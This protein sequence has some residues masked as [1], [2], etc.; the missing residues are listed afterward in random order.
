MIRQRSPESAGVRASSC[1]SQDSWLDVRKIETHGSV[2]HDTIRRKTTTFENFDATDALVS[3][4]PPSGPAKDNVSASSTTFS[5]EFG[6]QRPQREHTDE[7]RDKLC[8]T[9]VRVDCEREKYFACCRN[10]EE[11]IVGLSS[12][13]NVSH[14]SETMSETATCEFERLKGQFTAD[15][16]ALFEQSRQTRAA[17]SKLKK[18][19]ARLARLGF[20]CVGIPPLTAKISA[21]TRVGQIGKEDDRESDLE[22]WLSWTEHES[23]GSESAQ[24]RKCTPLE[25]DI[26]R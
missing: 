4:S 7:L 12:V 8:L 2:D 17:E 23:Q 25:K 5:I 26:E 3:P 11:S 20:W 21:A 9:R 13:L 15:K 18:I 10:A 6:Q 1:S 14:T 24:L 16:N 19:E 22:S